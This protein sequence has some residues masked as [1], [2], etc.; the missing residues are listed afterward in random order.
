MQRKENEHKMT[1]KGQ[2]AIS[3]AEPS[4]ARKLKNELKRTASGQE[5]PRGGVSLG[6]SSATLPSVFS[7]GSVEAGM[8]GES[9]ACTVLVSGSSK[10]SNGSHSSYDYNGNVSSK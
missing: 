8:G 10:R 9:A 2:K 1:S 7:S 5:C 3:S 6:V 4:S